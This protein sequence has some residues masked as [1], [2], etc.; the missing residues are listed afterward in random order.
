MIPYQSQQSPIQTSING[1]KTM[2]HKHYIQKVTGWRMIPA[3]AVMFAAMI[4]GQS[5]A[6]DDAL[7]VSENGRVGV[8]TTNPQSTLHVQSGTSTRLQVSNTATAGTDQVMFRLEAQGNDKIRFALAGSGGGNSWTFDNTPVL[9]MFSISKVG[10]GLNEFTVNAA[11][12]GVF[13]GTV[14]ATNFLTSSSREVKTDI[15]ALDARTVLEQVVALPVSQWRYR[16]S[17]EGDVRIGPMA[18]D[19]QAVFGLGDGQHISSSDVGGIALASV[20][21]LYRELQQRDETIGKL[22]QHNRELAERLAALEQ[23]LLGREE[24]VQR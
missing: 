16:D 15:E 23:L 10:T 11:G 20:Q 5:Y 6:Q 13:R 24:L 18:E 17:A 14:T 7:A 19:F 1:E 3:V 21:G 9:N 4:S 2:I 12:N 22:E 8:G